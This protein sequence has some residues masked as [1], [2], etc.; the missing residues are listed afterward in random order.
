M[1]LNFIRGAA[2]SAGGTVSRIVRELRPGSGVVNTRGH[3]H[4]VATE[5]GMVNLHGLSLR[6][7]AEALIS[8]SHP[9]FRASLRE[10]L[11]ELKRLA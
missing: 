2:L 7:R 5:Y 9:D 1:P 8:I 4:W 6:E 10:Q 11:R 3:V